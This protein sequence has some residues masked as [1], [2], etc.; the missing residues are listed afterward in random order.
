MF[1]ITNPRWRH[2]PK[3]GSQLHSNY[4]CGWIVTLVNK[5]INWWHCGENRYGLIRKRIN[6]TVRIHLSYPF[7]LQWAIPHLRAEGLSCHSIKSNSRWALLLL[8]KLR[9]P[10]KGIWKRWL[11]A[12]KSHLPSAIFPWKEFYE[13]K[14]EL[15]L[16]SWVSVGEWY[17]ITQA[18]IPWL[19]GLIS[20]DH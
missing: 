5:N 8:D 13:V 14:R 18:E 17:S 15:V 10:A 2:C 16:G 6:P 9:Q 12:F 4:R 11:T 19:I 7:F 20:S 3:T 1:L